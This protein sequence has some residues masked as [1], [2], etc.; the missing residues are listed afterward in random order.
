MLR[1]KANIGNDGKML[2]L[3]LA[4]EISTFQ[5][6]ENFDT[7]RLPI[8]NKDTVNTTVVVASGETVVL[9]GM[10]S[11]SESRTVKKV[12]ILGDIPLIGWFFKHVDD[13]KNPE[14]LLIFVTATVVKPTG[15]FANTAAAP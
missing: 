5:G 10:I 14:H 12:P 9:G 7:A 13:E 3:A 2:L 8:I 6:Y 4:P 11:Q 1:V 15:E